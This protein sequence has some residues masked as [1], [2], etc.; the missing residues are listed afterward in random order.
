MAQTRAM[1]DHPDAGESLYARIGGQGAV[2]ALVD[3]FYDE[4]DRHPEA[5]GLRALHAKDLGEIRRVLKL[6]LGQ[7][8]GGPARYSEERGHPRLRARH[9]PFPIGTAERDAWLACM[10]TAL[11]ETIDDTEARQGIFDAMARLADFM[12]NR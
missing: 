1:T 4:M 12:R 10:R 3:R 5:T 9:L 2:D 11:E 6:Y 7:W 8:L